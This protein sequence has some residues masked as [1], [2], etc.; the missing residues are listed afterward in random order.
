MDI[1]VILALKNKHFAKKKVDFSIFIDKVK[2]YELMSFTKSKNVIPIL[3]LLI[4]S[5]LIIEGEEPKD[6]TKDELLLKVKR[7]QARRS[8]ASYQGTKNP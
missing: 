2:N 7:D 6:L 8:E 5:K 3:Q 4:D 1:D